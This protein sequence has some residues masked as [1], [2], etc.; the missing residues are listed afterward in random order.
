MRIYIAIIIML[1]FLVFI[2]S[3]WFWTQAFCRAAK[4]HD[5]EQAS[6]ERVEDVHKFAIQLADHYISHHHARG[7]PTFYED[8]AKNLP[9]IGIRVDV[10]DRAESFIEDVVIPFQLAKVRENQDILKASRSYRLHDQ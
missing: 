8:S 5:F 2:C 3:F 10:S 4:Q 6:H 7:T 9:H 1:I